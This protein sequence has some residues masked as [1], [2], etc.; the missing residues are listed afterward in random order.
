MAKNLKIALCGVVSA[1]CIAIMA[2][3]SLIPF[4]TYYIPM[5][6]GAIV[7]SI[8]IETDKRYAFFVYVTVSILSALIV[9]DKEAVAMYILFMG[10]YPILKGVFEGRFKLLAEWVLKL[11]TFNVSMVSVFLIGIHILGISKEEYTIGGIYLPWVFLLFGNVMFLLYDKL[12]S[13]LVVLYI[14]RIQPQLKK[15]AK[16]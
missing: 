10:Y 12:L 11:L 3:S 16:Y 14:H 2:C 5:I 1:L 7:V 6:A 9:P 13:Q 8:V 15:I 4:S